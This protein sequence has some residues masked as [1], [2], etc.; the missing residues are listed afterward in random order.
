MYRKKNNTLKSSFSKLTT[1]QWLYILAGVILLFPLY[2]FIR[3]QLNKNKEQKFEIDKENN[4]LQNQNEPTLDV[5]LDKIT[6]TKSL[7]KAA[8]DLAHHFGTKYSDANN[9]WDFL[10]PRGWTENDNEI[11]KILIYQRNNYALLVKLYAEVTNSRSLGND[12]RKYLDHSNRKKVAK[13][14]NF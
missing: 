11:E 12:I 7:Q 9:W 8:K 1:I 6:P 3:N 5:M 2:R 10:N 13:Y 14:I 4:F